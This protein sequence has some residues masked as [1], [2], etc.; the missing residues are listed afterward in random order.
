MGVK[1]L[2]IFT[3]KVGLD[4]NSIFKSHH[5]DHDG[6]SGRLR[7]LD[8]VTWTYLGSEGLFERDF[9]IS[10][11]FLHPPHVPYGGMFLE[12]KFFK[13]WT[14]KVVFHPNRIFKSHQFVV[15]VRSIEETGP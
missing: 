7:R 5:F 3:P 1:N 11:K 6:L 10:K 4:P 13:N 15:I 2:K 8:P 12:V 14:P 9:E